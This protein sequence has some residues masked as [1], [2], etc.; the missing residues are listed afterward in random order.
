MNAPSI[1]RAQ[2]AAE[3]LR[4]RRARES[5]IGFTEYTN[6]RYRTA[7]VHKLIAEQLDRVERG[8]IDRLML[9]IPPRTG[10]SELASRRFPAI[11]LGRKPERQFISAS[12][13]GDFAAEFGRDV[14]NL[15]Q[16]QEYKALFPGVRLAEDSQ[17]KNKWNTSAGGAYYAVGM[18]GQVMGRG[19]DILM[20]DDPFATMADA[21]SETSRKSVWEWYTGTAYNRLQKGGAVIVINHRMHEEDLCGMLLAQEAA[22]GDKFKV[23]QV[24]AICDD[25]EDQLGRQVGEAAWPE[26]FP[27]AALERTKRVMIPRFWSALYQ[28]HPAPESGTYF[29]RDWLKPYLKEPDRKTLS[30]YGASDY[31]V[32]AD[33]GDFTVHI[34]AGVDPN[35]NIYLLDM[36]R[37]Q[38]ESPEW[39]ESWCD[40]VLKW[41]P[42]GWA[43]ETGQ[44]KAGVGPWLTARARERK[45]YCARTP[46][47][48]NKGDKSIRAQS[49]RG[50]MA[51]R[52]LFV[53]THAPWYPDLLAELM[54][55][56]AG[57][58]DDIADALGLLGQLLDF[59]T[60]GRVPKDEPLPKRDAYRP[61]SSPVQGGD[62]LTM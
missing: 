31:A 26:E 56:P 59:M 30:I 6:P 4:R 11:A 20:I 23:V 21:Q 41:R 42:M 39:A 46:F 36:W 53:P 43:E 51:L 5:L 12:A 32:T 34:V 40:L 3:I 14:R 10:K 29:E 13:S 57:K 55:F 50:R 54:S 28:Q 24:P 49:M 16:S 37:K 38:S 8:E 62:L 27:L 1:T 60:K 2:A 22:G 58:N 52:G 15:I 7:K 25:I 48:T 44:I 45:A 33:G 9:L 47:P 18:G 17:A 35:D 61:A 19:A